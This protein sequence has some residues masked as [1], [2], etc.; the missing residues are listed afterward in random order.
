MRYS[1]SY[2]GNFVELLTNNE[3]R[4]KNLMIEY[5]I[6]SKTDKLPDGREVKS[7][8]FTKQNI[9]IRFMPMR[10]DYNFALVNPNSKSEEVFNEA[11]AFFKLL[12]EIFPEAV[13]QRIAIVAQ[14]FIRNE[15]GIA[16]TSFADKMGLSENFGDCNELAFKINT[17]KTYFERLNSVVNVD[18]GEAKNNKTQEKMPVLLVS[19]DVNTMAN[20]QTPRFY[21]K[22]F[23]RDFSD[24]FVEVESRF[25]IL[26]KY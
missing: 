20:N 18:M 17:P 1:Y 13:G 22:D 4:I 16:V 2:I 12:G 21:P 5:E 8:M 26:E 3:Q 25:Q 9:N 24:L 6:Q 14:C 10:V 23:E 15:D 11:K 19:L 7:L